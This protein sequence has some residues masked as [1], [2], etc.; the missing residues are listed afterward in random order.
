[1]AS[2]KG[3]HPKIASDETEFL[4]I[5]VNK[6]QASLLGYTIFVYG[7]PKIGKTTLAASWPQPL[8]LSCEVRGIRA[9]PVSH[10]KIRSWEQ[11]LE[12][13]ELL[14]KPENAK[15]YRTVIID[16]SDL[17]YKYC[18]VHCCNKYGFDHPSDQG[19]GKGWERVSDEFLTVVL[20]LFDLGY[21]LIFISHAKSAEVT[22]D[23]ETYTR[24]DPTLAGPAR[25]V[26]LPLVDVIFYMRAK[27]MDDGKTVR[28]ITTK[29]VRE[30]EAGDRTKG[31]TDLEIRIP[32]EKKDKAYDLIN[33]KF[34]QNVEIGS[35]SDDTEE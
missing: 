12:S 31:L 23:W 35:A 32:T 3:A 14:K 5:E 28:S 34:L 16:T 8:V 30:Y 19:W 22:S 18:L 13:V 33:R 24:I 10:I 4:G 7:A 20:E 26:L 6:P 25:K 1:M 15:K 11:M 21:T 17:M 9:M 29:A 27:E 2:K